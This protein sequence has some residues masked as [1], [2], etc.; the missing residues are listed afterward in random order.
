MPR[1]KS[2][3]Y[4]ALYAPTYVP[5][6]VVA[7]GGV[8]QAA[9]SGVRTKIATAS[10]RTQDESEIAGAIATSRVCGAQGR[11]QGASEDRKLASTIREAIAARYMHRRPQEQTRDDEQCVQDNVECSAAMGSVMRG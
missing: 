9:A 4:S 10:E 11:V 8:A 7:F 6:T 3:L 2:W 5:L 1:K